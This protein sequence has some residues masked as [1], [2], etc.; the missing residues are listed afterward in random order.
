ATLRIPT[1]GEKASKRIDVKALG[2]WLICTGANIAYVERGSVRF[3]QGTM[4]VYL[5]A[6]GQIE[7]T[8]TLSGLDGVMTQP[9]AWKRAV[10]LIR[11]QKNDSVRLARR[12]FPEHAGTTFE[13]LHSHNVAEASL[14]ALYGAARCDL[15]SLRAPA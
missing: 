4:S 8:V 12:V 5:R 2:E 9:G 14:I 13:Y 1:I 3:G 11:A 6:C 15:V 7:A 10:G